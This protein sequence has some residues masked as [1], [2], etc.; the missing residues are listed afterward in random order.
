MSDKKRLIQ[1][2][3]QLKDVADQLLEC[4]KE[5]DKEEK[6]EETESKDVKPPAMLGM[7]LRKKLNRY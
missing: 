5:D 4:A 7:I 3:G 2:A 6:D 1:L